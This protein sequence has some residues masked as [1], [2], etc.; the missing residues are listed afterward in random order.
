MLL[1]SGVSTHTHT[2]THT[3]L[4][5]AQVVHYWVPDPTKIFLRFGVLNNK[6]LHSTYCLNSKILYSKLKK[7]GNDEKT[8]E[9]SLNFV[10]NLAQR[11]F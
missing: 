6:N 7:G 10:F 8:T 1:I 3:Y 4:R 2:H 5:N 11:I 9:V